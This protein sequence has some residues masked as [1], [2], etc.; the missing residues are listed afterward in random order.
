MIEK[1]RR[2]GSGAGEASPALRP[3]HRIAAVALLLVLSCASVAAP[4]VAAPGGGPSGDDDGGRG[5]VSIGVQ[6]A[7]RDAC[8]AV[9]PPCKCDGSGVPTLPPGLAKKKD[10]LP[11]GLAKREP[12]WCG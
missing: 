5:T 11:P 4:A 2:R 10:A 7:P 3:T 9:R 6:I 8:A 1:R 12:G